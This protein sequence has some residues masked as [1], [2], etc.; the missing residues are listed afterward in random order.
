MIPMIPTTLL[1]E[2]HGEFLSNYQNFH[3]LWYTLEIWNSL[4]LLNT[5]QHLQVIN[6]FVINI[7]EFERRSHIPFL[8]AVA[9]VADFSQVSRVTFPWE[10]KRKYNKKECGFYKIEFLITWSYTWHFIS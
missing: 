6:Y 5:S 1:C 9:Y 10:N 4:K 8:K 2:A 7:I 3:V